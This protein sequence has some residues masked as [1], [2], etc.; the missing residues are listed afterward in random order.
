MPA[1]ALGTFEVGRDAVVSSTANKIERRRRIL[2]IKIRYYRSS[3]VIGQQVDSVRPAPSQ[4]CQDDGIRNVLL[5]LSHAPVVWIV[6]PVHV[7]QAGEALLEE[8]DLLVCLSWLSRLGHR[9]RSND[10]A[11][12]GPAEAGAVAG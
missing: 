5:D 9:I 3:R 11:A 2:I 12:G 4:M 8:P 1:L 7:Q 10:V 6:R